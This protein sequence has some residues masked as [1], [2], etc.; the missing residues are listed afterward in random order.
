M[1]EFPEEHGERNLPRPHEDYWNQTR[2]PLVNLA[3]LLPL[4]VVYEVGVWS[5]GGPAPEQVRNG[6][7]LWMRSGLNRLGLQQPFLLPMLVLTLLL[8]WHVAGRY[9]RRCPLDALPGMM[10]ESVVCAFLLV[11]LGQG[12]YAAFAAFDTRPVLS[13]NTPDAAMLAVTFL[14][15]GI[16]EEVLFRLCLLSAC[17]GLLRAGGL[18]MRSSTLPAV[19]LSSV[20]FAVAHVVGPSAEAFDGFRFSFRLLA[21]GYF[22]LLFVWRGLGISVGAHAGYDLLV[23]LL[24]P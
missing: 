13:T 23:G 17:A 24:M 8:G 6:A 16:Y 19:A 4:L 9:P 14:G 12:M 5:V 20:A 21:G 15:A 3:F 18:G 1:V 2:L 10:A 11:A 7:D 22:G